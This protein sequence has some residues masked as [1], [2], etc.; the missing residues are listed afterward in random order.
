MPSATRDP[1]PPAAVAGAR[2]LSPPPP[3]FLAPPARRPPT[4]VRALDAGGTARPGPGLPPL[5]Y[6]VMELVEGGA[7]DRHVRQLGPLP[8]GGACDYIRQAAAGLQAAHDRHLIHR[9]LKPSNLLL[10]PGRQVK[11]V[12]FGLA[13][14]FSSRLTDPRALL[15]SVEFMPPEQSHDPSLVGKEADVYGLG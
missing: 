10:T 13:R 7:L 4:T 8:Q 3:A 12:D 1:A 6:L 15:G 11:V 5:I 2:P 9:D 14:Q